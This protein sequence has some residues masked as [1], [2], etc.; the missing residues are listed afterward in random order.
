MIL[1]EITHA[2]ELSGPIRSKP[3]TTRDWLQPVFPRFVPIWIYFNILLVIWSYSYMT[4]RRPYWCSK[5]NETAAMLVYQVNPVGLELFS[6]ANAFFCSNQFAYILAT[7]VKTLY[8][9]KW[10]NKRACIPKSKIL[11]ACLCSSECWGHLWDLL[12]KTIITLSVIRKLE[13]SP[14]EHFCRFSYN[15]QQ[16]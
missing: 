6:S 11:T 7:W 10:Y 3:I 1:A 13:R 14:W 4:S 12:N 9:N 2:T 8:T 16:N 15:R 5:N